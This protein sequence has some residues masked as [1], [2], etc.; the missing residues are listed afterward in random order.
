MG[1]DW[2]VLPVGMTRDSLGQE[3]GPGGSLVFRSQ[4]YFLFKLFVYFWFCWVFIATFG[5]SLVAV[6]R[7]YSSLWCT[8]FSFWWL[9][10]LW[11]TDSRHF[12]FS[13]HSTGA[14]RIGSVVGAHGLSCF[15]ACGIFLV[16]GSNL[17]PALAGGFLTT[18][19]PG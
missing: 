13:S 1:R 12:H 14:Q 3:R 17:S 2:G 6:S 11:S 10:L 8:A 5:L 19:P 7:S 9:L 18:E 16:Q 15:A 4:D